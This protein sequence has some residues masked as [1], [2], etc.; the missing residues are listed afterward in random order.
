MQE[1]LMRQQELKE[2]KRQ[3]IL[4]AAKTCIS[5]NGLAGTSMRAIAQGSGY[6]LGAAYAYFT[7]K[8]DIF[9]A[10]LSFSFTDLLRLLRSE[11]LQSG[12]GQQKISLTFKAFLQY[13]L[14]S[15]EDRYLLLAFYSSMA[16]GKQGLSEDTF[17]HLNNR[18]LSV[19]GMLA[20]T[21]H[22][23]GDLSAEDA[24]SETLQAM[25]FLLGI[26]MMSTSGQLQ[27]MGQTPQE[28]VDQYLDQMLLRCNR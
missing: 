13:F 28:M 11:L 12:P 7:S 20:N 16:D 3:K 2:F 8:E 10:L 19:L 4:S 24:Q 14:S 9:A 18:F 5:D 22:E 23:Y 1:R 17:R 26:L 27:L 25:T 15:K 21:V 6:S